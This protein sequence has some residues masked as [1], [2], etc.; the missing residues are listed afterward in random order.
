MNEPIEEKDPLDPL[1][2]S[3]VERWRRGE[4]PAVSEY[5]ARY[6]DLAERIRKVFP[7][8][9]VLEELGSVG[10]G[11]GPSSGLVSSSAPVPRQLGEYR[12]LRELGRGGMGIVYEAVQQSLGR[13]VALKVLPLHALLKPVHV[14]RFRRESRAAAQLHHTNIVPVFGVGEQRGIHY[15]AMQFIRGQGLDE[16]LQEVKRL[17][18]GIIAKTSAPRTFLA[19]GMLSGEFVGH[20]VAPAHGPNGTSISDVVASPPPSQSAIR[21]E[22][23]GGSDLTSHPGFQYFRSVAQLGVQ[24]AE[25]LDYA[26]GQGVLHRDI[27]PSNLLV[28]SMG[29][30]WITD[31]GLAKADESDE[32]TCLGD[33]V[34]TLR[35]MA[36]ERFQGKAD[37]RSDVYGLGVTLYEMLTLS[38]AF[39]DSNR[40]RLIQRIG[41]EEPP[42]PRRL[43]P[44]VPRDLET[45]VLKTMARAP[46]DRYATAGLLAEDLRSFLA[47]RPIRA[48]QVSRTEQVWRWCR[49]NPALALTA[50]FAAVAL[51]STA[52]LGS[53]LAF[54]QHRA[55]EQLA[56]EQGQTMAA[57]IQ[58]RR[59][60]DQ[61]KSA[62]QEAEKQ[63]RAAERLSASY[64]LDRGIGL[65]EQGDVALGML[66]LVRSLEIAPAHATDLKRAIRANLGAWRGELRPLKALLPHNDA[67]WAVAYSPDGTKILTGGWDREGRL[68]DANT[69]APVG[70]PLT[71]GHLVW[72]ARFSPD[73]RMLALAGHEGGQL[74]DVATQSPRG[75]DFHT[76]TTIRA[77]VFTADGRFIL[78]SDFSGKVL[79]WDAR[80]GESS[81]EVCSQRSPVAALA[82][83]P[84]G[85]HVATGSE[86]GV[87]RVWDMATGTPTGKPLP[88]EAAVLAMAFSGSGKFLVTGCAD[89]SVHFWNPAAGAP[90]GRPL[91]HQGPVHCVAV[92]PNDRLLLTGSGDRTARIWNIETRAPIGP[93]LQHRGHVYAVA[94][95][96]DGNSVVTG[97]SENVVR[98]W[99]I[100][101]TDRVR[102]PDMPSSVSAHLLAPTA[103]FRHRGAVRAVAIAPD[104]RSLL[105]GSDDW[106]ARL[107]DLR[108]RTAI[109]PFLAHKS[110]VRAI[111]IS[112]DGATLLTGSFDCS[113]QLWDNKTG[114]PIGKP[115]VHQ[116]PVWAVAFSPD[117]RKFVTGDREGNVRRWQGCPP[118]A[119]D[120]F[121]RASDRVNA[122]AWSPDGRMI[123]AAVHASAGQ[124]GTAILRDSE[125]GRAIYQLRHTAAVWAMAFSRDSRRLLTASWDGTARLWDTATG[126]PMGP[127]FQHEAKIEGAAF[128]PDEKI[129]AT[130]GL[131][132]TARLWDAGTGKAIGPPMVH[133]NMVLGVAF[134][135]DGRSVATCS[136]DARLRIW[137]I[138][139][140]VD[141]PVD[142]VRQQVE[143]LTALR[144][145]SDGAAIAVEPRAWLRHRSLHQQVALRTLQIAV[146]PMHPEPYRSRARTYERLDQPRQAIADCNAGLALGPTS[147]EL[148][149]HLWLIRGRCLASL[150]EDGGV[151]DVER[152]LQLQPQDS[153]IQDTLAWLYVMGPLDRRDPARALPLA[154]KAALRDPN[155]DNMNTLGVVY[156][157]LKRFEEAISALE[158]NS[159]RT[160]PYDLFPLSISHARLRHKEKAQAYYDQAVKW[161]AEHA[162]ELRTL[163]AVELAELQQEAAELLRVSSDS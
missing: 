98:V 58:V 150:K 136:M 135:P 57:L 157:R 70:A 125:T 123:A 69:G 133:G 103:S 110:S 41:Q 62:W 93:P 37:A 30:V 143:Q 152:A 73:G 101:D 108:S 124:N 42:R 51:V 160:R 40:A 28:D 161:L 66:W 126:K 102:P 149:A 13:H 4:R 76:P 114:K 65:C 113:A 8:L 85:K 139:A 104:G 132:G 122:L 45:I 131:D 81:G 130:A 29:R 34:G 46:S 5:T 159:S 12:I 148:E 44:H 92:N 151:A 90:L 86:D 158:Q 145:D 61:T 84:D 120:Y 3:F 43:D 163:E 91:L 11:D 26:H 127:I 80:T 16:V 83:S 50:G 52:I 162:R 97:G 153:D 14:E 95:S 71:R 59:E 64:A 33:L 155:P 78:T 79:R 56:K 48:R 88:H 67:V 87:V 106:S 36:P 27:K 115:M 24:I 138:P 22:S 39:E 140:H 38:P 116:Y 137:S 111:A 100:T 147:P 109:Q 156:C 154:E 68:W 47:N 99:D 17:R 25:A 74:F 31:F 96:P 72:T 117:G 55:A 9:V 49:R 32:L 18:T 129:V 105:T 19:E 60:Q 141:E 144:L 53:A 128:S 35:Y 121:F 54:Q 7:A 2:E 146:C 94:F 77:L 21:P 23:Q 10:E 134:H 15:Y 107:W 119:A 118:Q 75:K 112:P 6:P 20:S 142:E 63:K 1:A 89:G 82:V